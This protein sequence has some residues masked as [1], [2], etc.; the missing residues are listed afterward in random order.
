MTQYK[1][2]N[3]DTYNDDEPCFFTTFDGT[4]VWNRVNPEWNTFASLN[5]KASAEGHSW[6]PREVGIPSIQYRWRTRNM[7]YRWGPGLDDTSGLATEAVSNGESWTGATGSTPPTGW[8]T[9]GLAPGFT[10]DAG[11]LVFDPFGAG[12]HT[13]SQDLSTAIGTTYVVEIAMG[14]QTT[15]GNR[16]TLLGVTLPLPK[17]A[18]KFAFS[19]KAVATTT[20]LTF[21]T[22]SLGV[23]HLDYV[24]C[25]EEGELTGSGLVIVVEPPLPDVSGPYL[26]DGA[27]F[28]INSKTCKVAF[29]IDDDAEPDIWLT[30]RGVCK[31][32]ISDT[33]KLA[34]SAQLEALG[35]GTLPCVDAEG[36]LK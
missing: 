16:I 34:V 6:Q 19:F 8:D 12:D 17:T 10:I 36:N 27:E 9:T 15:D 33:L 22:E 7:N 20:T 2:V 32:D 13:L 3:G 29:N 25:Y 1:N 23:L 24:R 35:C 18:G 14:A 28:W 5:A 26:A 4:L 30:K 21:T 31:A 11:T